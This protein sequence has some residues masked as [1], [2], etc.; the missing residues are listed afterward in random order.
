MHTAR[1]VVVAATALATA[2]TTSTA[3]ATAGGSGAVR[4]VSLTNPVAGCTAG[5]A[6]GHNVP[7]SETEPFVSVDP[8]HSGH[9][10]VTWQQD[11]WSNGGAHA[12]G[13]AWTADGE[14]YRVGVLPFG[15][16]SGGGDYHRISDIWVSF[17]PDGAAYSS[18][19]QFDENTNRGGVGAA[20]SFDGGATWRYA[21]PVV[22]DDDPDLA[23]DKNSVT[24]DQV[25]AG[26]AY[27]VWDRLDASD[28]GFDGPAL[29][30]VTHD[31]GRTWSRPAT[32]IDTAAVAPFTQTI[33]NIV[34]EDAHG[35]L[36]D[37]AN[38]ITFT[39]AS[40]SVPV[41]ATYVM[42]TSTDEGATWSRPTPVATDSSVAEA[43]PN[44]PDKVLRA[45]AG[46]EAVAVDPVSG[47]IWMTYE[48]SDFSGGAYDQIE[49]VSSDDGGATWS[50]P[51]LV[52]EPGVPAFTPV[53]AVDHEG[54]VAV[55]YYD[56][57]YLAPGNT[58]TLPTARFVK[59]YRGGDTGLT[60][61][62][63]RQITP[64]FDWLL[65]P[66]AGG[67]MLGDY[68]G[69]APAGT[70]GVQTV[71]VASLNPA[72]GPTDVYSGVFRGPF[73]GDGAGGGAKVAGPASPG[74]NGLHAA[75]GSHGKGRLSR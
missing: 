7:G 34:V 15:Q 4:Q 62:V 73:G 65:A 16:C 19:L 9:A 35:K 8:H 29:V 10:I 69:M 53:V 61:G 42:T 66:F 75:A 68:E 14:H 28:D 41:T 22:A 56:L 48:G 72:T 52:S 46:L 59:T 70:F 21:Q 33:G 23:D 25:H 40:G 58:T 43:D 71:F 5:A 13:Y 54:T 49:M 12:G 26:V 47:R 44:A 55:S 11:R 63:E 32:M 45:G 74:T 18:V 24:A 3:F 1:R 67:Y 60:H 57:R 2:L 37:F 20:T 36:Y 31:H 38:L 50:A 17:G 39:D 30:S 6:N 27:Q 51:A 64:Q